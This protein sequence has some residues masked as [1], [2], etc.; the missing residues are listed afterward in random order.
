MSKHTF[1]SLR[2]L[3]SPLIPHRKRIKSHPSPTPTTTRLLTSLHLSIITFLQTHMFTLQLMPKITTPAKTNKALPAIP[4][5]QNEEEI[6]VLEEQRRLVEGFLGDAL[7]RRKF[8]DAASLRVGLEE[9]EGEIQR[10][11]GV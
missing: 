10:R 1:N 3:T 6:R 2:L 5:S 9:L 11:R 8:E 7:R 4:S